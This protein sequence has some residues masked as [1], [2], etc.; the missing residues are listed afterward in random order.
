MAL[1]CCGATILVGTVAAMGWALSL[2]RLAS[3]RPQYIPMAPSTAIAFLVLGA[4]LLL[5]IR[6]PSP[7]L[8]LAL[9]LAIA[10][11]A[12]AQLIAFFAEL[13]SIV[14]RL[15][16]PAPESFGRVLT[17]RMSPLT[18]LGFLLASLGLACLALRG[19]HHRLGSIGGGLASL[20][21]ILSL[22]V[23]LGYAY[24]T[25][26]LYGGSVV[27]MALTTAVAFACLSLALIG[28][29][30]TDHFPLRSVS[31]SS[32]TATLLRAFLP[33]APAVILLDGAFH[34]L[35]AFNPAF[36]SVASALLVSTV[37]AVGVWHVARGLGRDMD[38]AQEERRRADEA[39]QRLTAIVES[40]TD[41][42]YAQTLDGVVT[43]WHPSAERLFGHTADE[44]VGQPASL[45]LPPNEQDNGCF[46]RIKAGERVHDDAAT[47]IRK[48][49]SEVIVAL[50]VS[51]V[52][53]AS[54]RVVGAST[55]ARDVTNERRAQTELRESER[56]LQAFV[57]SDAV[58]ILFGDIHGNVHDAN[59]ALLRLVG[60][61]RDDLEAGHLR[62]IDITPT[63]FLPLDEEH[64]AEA[65]ARGACTPYQKQYVRK[66][67]TRVWVLVGYVL[68][69]PERER[70]VAFVLDISEQKK[71]E[72]ALQRSEERFSSVFRVGPLAIGMSEISSGRLIDVN[73]S[74]LEFFGYE[75][76]EMLGR[77]VHELHLWV[78]PSEREAIV[79][80]LLGGETV[81][82][83]EVPFRRKS[84][85]T[86]LGLLSMEILRLPTVSELVVVV[87]IAD[88]TERKQLESQL[89]HAQKMEAIGRLA[90]GVAH[91]FNNLLGVI[92]GYG[93]L[94]RR[95]VADEQRGR[96]DQILKAAERAAGFTRQLLAFSRKQV[97]EPRLLDLNALLSDLETMLRTLI[98]EDVD[99]V[100]APGQ[101]LGLVRADPGQLEQVIMNLCVNARDA[102]N[103]GGLLRIE[104]RSVDLDEAYAE[105]SGA[106]EQEPI[107]PGRYA[108][109]SVS[110]TGCGMD[111]ETLSHLFEPF[112]TTKEKGKGTGLGLSTVY[113]IVRQSGGHIRAYSEP[114]QGSIFRVYLPCANGSPPSVD[115]VLPSR[116]GRGWETILLAEDEPSLRRLTREVL[117]D[118]GYRVLEASTGA[119][120]IQVS[121]RHPD[122]I[123]LLL[124]D[125][126]MP[127]M[128]GK[129][130]SEHL[131]AR[132]PGMRVLYMSGYTDDIVAERGVLEPGVLLLAKPFTSVTLLGRVREA[133]D[134]PGT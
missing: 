29:A 130:L 36:H 112:F 37:V 75:R 77:T 43:I 15:L 47:R 59:D 114:R 23:T 8:T 55:I 32:A 85:E 56:K 89:L 67:G 69:E 7:R 82:N 104:T 83:L 66:D 38:R 105:R 99:L 33:I 35:P 30:G 26:P 4:T 76:E 92:L 40:S 115:A 62:W 132:R 42:I 46:E 21:F 121:D 98:G 54:G 39:T 50:T 6:R 113:G 88:I 65:R 1:A 122:P 48:D 41:A 134:A 133:L 119:E 52:R 107:P 95:Q 70:S 91:D 58:G 49:G 20:A 111:R 13:P 44:I 10:A 128:D 103:E 60:Y 79:A 19:E 108:R 80:R 81:R 25:P 131:A 118:S 53:D 63:E 109:L 5:D 28:H 64:V 17:A 125:V 120:A 127:G 14:E 12:G 101:D 34:Q 22:V 94:L 61:T 87:M 16:V 86:R 3:I 116:L 74:C 71:A 123:H 73:E 18:A 96:I 110:D 24:G 2:H 102:M 126:V 51:P 11:L 78:D 68:L 117:E 124:T 27:P 129:K 84:G 97:L 72:E 9:P 90:G 57:N 100:I 45:L 93:E 106:P 31:G